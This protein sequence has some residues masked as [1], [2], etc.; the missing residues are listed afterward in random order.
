MATL[1]RKAKASREEKDYLPNTRR[2]AALAADKKAA[3]IKAYDVSGLTVIADAFVLCTATS[4]PQMKA[5]VNAVREGMK[6]IG[7][8]P[9]ST[10]GAVSGGWVLMDYGQIIFHVFRQQARDFYDLDG[11]W[12]D[13]QEI[14]LEQG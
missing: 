13:A 1:V 3:N 14:K 10:E 7:V 2:I 9:L 5:I 8:A 12:A 11:M 6:E 4:E